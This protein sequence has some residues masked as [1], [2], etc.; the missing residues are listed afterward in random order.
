MS[1]SIYLVIVRSTPVAF[2]YSFDAAKRKADD[3]VDIFED[4][5]WAVGIDRTEQVH[6]GALRYST[7]IELRDT[8]VGP[9]SPLDIKIWRVDNKD[10]PLEALAAQAE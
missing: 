6:D 1:V 4:A 2:Y 9:G 5:P 10:S 7:T 8:G 3:L